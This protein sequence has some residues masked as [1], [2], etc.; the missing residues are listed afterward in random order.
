MERW[1]RA[2]RRARFA[3]FAAATLAVW[4]IALPGS[5]QAT[6]LLY[7][8]RSPSF[9]G[10]DNAALTSAQFEQSLKAQRATNQAAA[11]AAAKPAVTDPNA[12]FV[13]A[14]TSQLTGLVAQSIAQKIANSQNGQAGTIQSGNVVITYVNSDGQLAVTITSPTGSTTLSIPVGG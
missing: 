8:L 14:L 6:D 12:A 13:A 11:Q 9:G 10:T 5:A 4:P 7:L 3:L 2:A 1:T